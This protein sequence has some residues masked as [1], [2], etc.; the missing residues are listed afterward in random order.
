ML[1]TVGAQPEQTGVVEATLAPVYGKGYDRFAP[2]SAE[3]FSI[4]LSEHIDQVRDCSLAE[5]D[6]P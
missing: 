1:T 3:A 5:S 6:L 4:W 2:L